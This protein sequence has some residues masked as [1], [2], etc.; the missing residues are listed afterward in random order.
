MDH[1]ISAIGI[2]THPNEVMAILQMPESSCVEDMRG[3]M[4]MVNYLG[5]PQ[6]A[7]VTRPLKDL[8]RKQNEWV[9]EET[10]QTAFQQL[11]EGLSAPKALVQCSHS[12][13]TKVAA[14]A[15]VYG[16]G[17]VL[18]QKQADNSWQPVTY[19]SRGL[20]DTEKR[21]VQVE[22]DLPLA[23]RICTSHC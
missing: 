23:C 18:T 6:L 7:A 2:E 8:L 1:E 20:T 17:A 5:K 13:E 9:W 15:S 12:A 22:K 19:I 16:I 3:L 4:G 14:D 11:K 10:Q 21:Y